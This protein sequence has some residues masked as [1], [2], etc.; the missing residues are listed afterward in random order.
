M[1]DLWQRYQDLLPAYVKFLQNDP[2]QPV[3]AAVGLYAELLSLAAD[4]EVAQHPI[5]DEFLYLASGQYVT[6]RPLEAIRVLLH[7]K[8]RLRPNDKGRHLVDE[9][10]FA[11][12]PRQYPKRDVTGASLTGPTAAVASLLGFPSY[13]GFQ[14]TAWAEILAA[15]GKGEAVM[16]TAPTGAGKTESF[17]TPLV[18]ATGSGKRF[19]IAYPRRELIKD[20]V[21]RLLKMVAK[22]NQ[23]RPAH[24]QAVIGVQLGGIADGLADNLWNDGDGMMQ[25]ICTRC[26][27]PLK[28]TS[29]NSFICCCP[30]RTMPPSLWHRR[31]WKFNTARRAWWYDRNDRTATPA[32]MG[33]IDDLVVQWPEVLPCPSCGEGRHLRAPARAFL[34]EKAGPVHF[35]C[36]ACGLTAPLSLSKEQHIKVKP[37]FL[38]TNVESLDRLLQDPRYAEANYWANI[39]GIALDE[40]HVY[41]QL[42]GAH[43]HHLLDRLGQQKGAPL[44]LI[45]CS[46]TIPDPADFGERLFG[47]PIDR[48]VEASDPRFPQEILSAEYFVFLKTPDDENASA[49]STMLQTVM[50]L[51]HAILPKEQVDQSGAQVMVFSDSLDVIQRAELQLTD[52][53]KKKLYWYRMAD[54]FDGEWPCEGLDEARCPNLADAGICPTYAAGE[55]WRLF[56]EGDLKRAPMGVTSVSAQSKAGMKE[57]RVADV[58]IASPALEVG[59]D[60]PGVGATVHYK[61]PRA[62]FSF[63]QRK[64]RAGRRPT[65]FPFTVAVLAGADPMDA[66]TFG[67]FDR[68]VKGAYRLPLN[69]DNPLIKAVHQQY[70]E[71]TFQGPIRETYLRLL[72]TFR[73]K[74]D[75]L[76]ATGWTVVRDA[77]TCT[78]WRDE[79]RFVLPPA[80]ERGD[81]LEF[82]KRALE[83]QLKAKRDEIERLKDHFGPA[84]EDR[85]GLLGAMQR[86]LTEVHARIPEGIRSMA[87]FSVQVWEEVTDSMSA[88]AGQV[89]SATSLANVRQEVLQLAGDFEGALADLRR[90]LLGAGAATTEARGALRTLQREIDN[91][92][93]Q[94]DRHGILS[95]VDKVSDLRYQVAALE[96]LVDAAHHGYRLPAE[97]VKKYQQAQFYLCWS[98]KHWEN[99]A[100]PQKIAYYLPDT[101]FDSPSNLLVRLENRTIP[102]GGFMLYSSYIPY[103]IFYRFGNVPVMVSFQSRP[104]GFDRG[105]IPQVDVSL[106]G[107]EGIHDAFHG[108]LYFMP[109]QIKARF[110]QPIESQAGNRFA[111]CPQCYNLQDGTEGTCH[112]CDTPLMEASIHAV[113]YVSRRFHVLEELG[114]STR[115]RHARL[116]GLTEVSGVD[117]N[118]RTRSREGQIRA[119][120]V[121]PLGYKYETRG[122]V[123]SLFDLLIEAWAAYQQPSFSRHKGIERAAEMARAYWPPTNPTEA[124][125]RTTFLHT[126]AHVL[127]KLVA[128]LCGVS[129]ES[130]EYAWDETEG[131]VAV[132][133]KVTGGAGIT[134][135]F[136]EYLTTSAPEVYQVLLKIVGVPQPG[137]DGSPDDI[138]IAYCQAGRREQPHVVS[139]S[140]AGL[141][142]ECL[143]DRVKTGVSRA[144]LGGALL[145]DV[146]AEE[147]LVVTLGL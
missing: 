74:N 131:E 62:V 114:A 95:A 57:A 58:V 92:I 43:V 142:V 75:A 15:I 133:E 32:Y 120:Y 11:V 102:E 103:K 78:R 91:L 24:Q 122:L 29:N 110:V 5:A 72:P 6:L 67:Q 64:G 90:I 104:A 10:A 3:T 17:M 61:T 141:L 73:Y 55:C 106:E 4:A 21:G 124:D 117:V 54:S 30:G 123:L 42:Y 25:V 81:G 82:A 68:L 14:V 69:P 35:T 27:K 127:V 89:N 36:P 125:F 88:L 23:T 100:L 66:F 48:L 63:I 138:W 83:E 22:A 53:E 118:Y 13:S 60:I 37:H 87:A 1:N 26:A 2:Y 146:E 98:C 126:A 71:E 50:V 119:R 144:A 116:D 16:L 143:T 137:S 28:R 47:R 56:W 65:Q 129:E 39:D 97:V 85:S 111:L 34:D 94:V 140:L 12:R 113:P 18:H 41:F 45:G 76:R 109:R 52:A 108:H 101:Y 145:V 8:Q 59:V 132:W 86:A 115:L 134:D 49:L 44:T 80:V 93:D 130:L 136:M 139:Q 112:Q 20:Q 33:Y 128:A 9:L 70:L 84:V 99:C 79:L 46:A 51:G 40:V 96:K 7:L 105:G 31:G 19:I 135:L 107:M 147:N 121:R 38:V 77:A